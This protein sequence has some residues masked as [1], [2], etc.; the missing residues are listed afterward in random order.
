MYICMTQE[1]ARHPALPAPPLSSQFGTCKTVTAGFW[2]QLELFSV[3]MT[4]EPFSS[5]PFRSVAEQI[6][7]SDTWRKRAP[8]ANS[9]HVRQSWPDSGLDLSHLQYERL[10]NH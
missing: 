5:F 4:A 9:A 1:G 10:T 7:G 3:R 2:P 6:G 8:K